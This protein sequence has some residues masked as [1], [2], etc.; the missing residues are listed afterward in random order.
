MTNLRS[1][2]GVTGTREGV[3]AEQYATVTQLLQ[4]LP[5]LELHHGDCIG[6]DAQICALATQLGLKLI[7]HPP[8]DH[9]L[10]AYVPSHL[11]L[12]TAP[13]L[14]R[15]HD[16]VDSSSALIATPKEME[17]IMRSGTWATIRYARKAGKKLYLVL[18]DGSLSE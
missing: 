9:R 18:P 14:I 13:F 5:Y 1:I 6:S 12:P 8:Q 2:V 17:E 7:A 15:N 3:T 11:V 4:D 10:R 16:I